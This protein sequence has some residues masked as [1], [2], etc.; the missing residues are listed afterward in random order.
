MRT[1][2][3][4]VAVETCAMAAL[5]ESAD[6]GGVPTRLRA[7]TTILVL[8]YFKAT[9]EESDRQVAV[10]VFNLEA[11]STLWLPIH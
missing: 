11:S 3:L 1:A 9:V 2:I 8:F 5:V 6:F 7:V 4:S 10:V